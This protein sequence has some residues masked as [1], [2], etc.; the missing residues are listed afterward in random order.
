M[1][2]LHGISMMSQ[3]PKPTP[4]ERRLPTFFAMWTIPLMLLAKAPQ[5]VASGSP[6]SEATNATRWQDVETKSASGEQCLVCGQRVFDGQVVQVRYKGRNFYVAEKMFKAFAEDPDRHFKKMQARAALFDESSLHI[7]QVP[8]LA[9]WFGLYV[10][11]SLVTS[12]LSGA[13][14]IQRGLP[15]VPWFFVGL[16]GNLAGLLV[17]LLNKKRG[18]VPELGGRLEKVPTTASPLP[19]PHCGITNHPAASACGGCGRSLSPGIQAE[20]ARV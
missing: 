18:T 10:L 17:L 4:K 20:V 19:C 7:D 6:V 14:A 3:H 5:S 9:L 12:A 16:A 11:L 15:P 8:S 13:L 1:L 2:S